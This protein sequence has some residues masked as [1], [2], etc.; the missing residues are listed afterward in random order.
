MAGGAGGNELGE[1]HD[2]HDADEI[3]A[4]CASCVRAR[5]RHM[6]DAMA[7][8]RLDAISL[9]ERARS[10]S[11]SCA[12]HAPFEAGVLERRRAQ[13]APLGGT[14]GEA[15]EDRSSCCS[16]GCYGATTCRRG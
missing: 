1:E 8:P 4:S 16:A 5:D 3:F 7:A 2:D 12:P 11:A 9:D 14:L 13:G 10:L 6:A 15:L